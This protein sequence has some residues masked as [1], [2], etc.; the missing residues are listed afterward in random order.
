MTSFE[1]FAERQSGMGL[2]INDF[3]QRPEFD[4]RGLLS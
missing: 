3:T 1:E 4:N 2:F